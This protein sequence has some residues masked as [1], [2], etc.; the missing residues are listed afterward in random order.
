MQLYLVCEV[1][2]TMQVQKTIPLL[3]GSPKKFG[4]TGPN[5]AIY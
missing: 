1:L 4:D 3:A 2:K 5:N